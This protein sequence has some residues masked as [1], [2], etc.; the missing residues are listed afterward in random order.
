MG[1][2]Q[3]YHL[4]FAGTQTVYPMKA[5]WAVRGTHG[6]GPKFRADEK[7]NLGEEG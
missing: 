5:R 3:T 4:D 7:G 6:V 2:L 1:D